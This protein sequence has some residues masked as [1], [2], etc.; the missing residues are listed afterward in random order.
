MKIISII[1]IH[2]IAMSL[3]SC[4][5]VRIYDGRL[6]IGKGRSQDKLLYLL[7]NAYFRPGL[8]GWRE[9]YCQRCT[10]IANN[11]ERRTS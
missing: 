4:A 2:F 9:V 8:M 5:T 10:G 3:V 11:A 1:L 7:I 6:L